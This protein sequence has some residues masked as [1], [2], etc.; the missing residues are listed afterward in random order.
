MTKSVLM[1]QE[2]I[3]NRWAR[4]RKISIGKEGYYGVSMRILP[5]R[6]ENIFIFRVSGRGY[7]FW[8]PQADFCYV[9]VGYHHHKHTRRI[10]FKHA[11]NLFLK[12]QELK[13]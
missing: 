3:L 12:N 2:A 1:K 7:E 10:A 4:R 8:L 6:T 13:N 11:C 5:G 9:L